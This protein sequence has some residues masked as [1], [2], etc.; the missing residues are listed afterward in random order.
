METPLS[1]SNSDPRTRGWSPP[2][3][4]L[5]ALVLVGAFEVT[6][7][8]ALPVEE[9]P[10]RSN[11][12]QSAGLRHVLD[13]HG[14]AEVAFVGASVTRRSIHIPNVR[15]VCEEVLGREVRVANYGHKGLKAELGEDVVHVLLREDPAPRLILYGVTPHQI[16]RVRPREMKTSWVW[17]LQDWWRE[18]GTQGPGVVSELPQVVR[19]ETRRHYRTFQVRYAKDAIYD[20]IVHDIP[21]LP[22]SMLGELHHQGG[23]ARMSLRN[24]RKPVSAADMEHLREAIGVCTK[25]DRFRF[26]PSR[27]QS[28]RNIQELCQS[29]GIRLVFFEIPLPNMHT[30]MFPPETHADFLQHMEEL[31]EESGAP[32]VSFESLGIRVTNAHFT[33]QSH[34]NLLGATMMTDALIEQVFR[35]ELRRLK[36][37]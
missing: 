28:L 30:E 7:R 8:A 22:S 25:D 27:I 21:L 19:N 18:W 20:R 32:F 11:L 37:Q 14:A 3:A 5:L 15:E 23:G 24:R 16:R 31:Q 12:R 13:H 10:T 29:R 36:S 1:T 35:P 4:L 34:L 26:S 17:T 9:F 2:W 6:L 33:D